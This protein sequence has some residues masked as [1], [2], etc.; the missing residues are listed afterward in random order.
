MSFQFRSLFIGVDF[1]I[2][3]KNLTNFKIGIKNDKRQNC[4]NGHI[5]PG[6]L[7]SKRTIYEDSYLAQRRKAQNFCKSQG[8]YT[9]RKL[10]TTTRTSFRSVLRSSKSH[11]PIYK[12]FGIFQSPTVH[13]QGRGISYIFSSHFFIF[14]HIYFLFLHISFLFLHVSYI[15]LHIYYIFLLKHVKWRGGVLQDF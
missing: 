9:G 13:I 10:H 3:L 7:Y 6:S 5:V 8:F 1:E 14:P 2:F 11:T 4:Q 15:F 12:E